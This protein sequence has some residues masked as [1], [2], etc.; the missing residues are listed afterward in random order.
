[1][2]AVCAATIGLLDPYPLGWPSGVYLGLE[3][4]VRDERSESMFAGL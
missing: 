2:P 1:M 4:L 3:L